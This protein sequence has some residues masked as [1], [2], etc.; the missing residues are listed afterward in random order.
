MISLLFSVVL[1]QTDNTPPTAALT[2]PKSVKAGQTVTAQLAVGFASGL[3]GYQ[4]PPSD[5][6]EIPV[7][8]KLKSGDAKVVKIAYPKGADMTMPGDTKPTKVYSGTVTIPL[9]IKVGK[10]GGPLV[11][12]VDY[13]QCTE[14]NC[15]PPASVTAKGTLQLKG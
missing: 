11:I 14:A 3:H 1:L 8:V 5:S 4:N 12:E 15:F 6:F 9:K 7:T 10:K 2:L 13:Q